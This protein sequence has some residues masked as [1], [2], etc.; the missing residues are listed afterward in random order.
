MTGADVTE[1]YD[2]LLANPSLSRNPIGYWLKILR[3]QMGVPADRRL[4]DLAILR[5][6][7]I[8]R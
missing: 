1:L 6:G 3:R 2:F 8:V 4:V 5:F 7:R